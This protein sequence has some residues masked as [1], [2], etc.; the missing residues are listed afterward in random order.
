MQK[1]KPGQPHKGWK[2]SAQKAAE[3]R[4]W[5]IFD[6]PGRMISGSKTSPK[7]HI[8][9]FNANVLS[10]SRGKFW[11]GDLDITA[12]AEELR[13][14]AVKEGEPIYVLREMDARFMNEADPKWDNAVAI[15]NPDGQI[16]LKS[17]L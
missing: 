7:G 4:R 1:R 13:A 8:C 5:S 12:D 9:V 6:G 14:L 3:P 15:I 10:R 16:D 17:T 11:F 2:T